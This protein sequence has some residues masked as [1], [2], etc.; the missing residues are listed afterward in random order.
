MATVEIKYLCTPHVG[1]PGKPWETF[2][3]KLLDVAA[4]RPYTP[5]VNEKTFELRTYE[6]AGGAQREKA[7]GWGW[8][9]PPGA[10]CSVYRGSQLVC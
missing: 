8:D 10:T 9:R 6:V 4:A 7:G 2:E 5:L 1:T 3:D